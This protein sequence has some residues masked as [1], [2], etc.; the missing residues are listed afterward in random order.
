MQRLKK[1]GR[2]SIFF[3]IRHVTI[4]QAYFKLIFY[5]RTDFGSQF[6]LHISLFY[7][8]LQYKSLG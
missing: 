8:L 5:E 1:A 3:H 4:A 7:T 2:S 6:Q